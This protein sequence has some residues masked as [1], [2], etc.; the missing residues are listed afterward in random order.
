MLPPANLKP[1]PALPTP[2][3][4]PSSLVHRTST[5]NPNAKPILALRMPDGSNLIISG[6]TRH[7]L[8]PGGVGEITNMKRR[9]W[10]RCR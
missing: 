3:N 5:Y 7:H 4:S 9:I 2:K 1:H 6:R 10:Q 8:L